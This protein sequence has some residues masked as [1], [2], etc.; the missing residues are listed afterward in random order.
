MVIEGNVALFGKVNNFLLDQ[1]MTINTNQSMYK[2]TEFPSNVTFKNI[3]TDS[4]NG[5]DLSRQAVLRSRN[6]VVRG[7]K[8]FT[9]NLNVSTITLKEGIL[10]DSFNPS[11]EDFQI[12]KTSDVGAWSTFSFECVNIGNIDARD[13]DI[14]VNYF[15]Q[16]K[17]FD[18]VW[19]KSTEQ[20]IIF[21]FYCNDFITL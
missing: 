8:T 3:V 5:I 7:R 12:L 2:D 17:K 9:R 6:N 11:V 20:V 15:P 4:V 21:F 18:N 13:V 1:F 19:L 14:H 10:I 16:L